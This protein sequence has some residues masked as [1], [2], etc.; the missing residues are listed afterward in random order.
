MD[1]QT[2]ISSVSTQV[3]VML[4]LIILGYI[5][6]KKYVLTEKGTSEL[7]NI[8]L[9][10][11]IPCVIMK[12]Y[13]MPFDK[14]KIQKLFF[15]YFLCFVIHI[16]YIVLANVFFTVTKDLKDR[17]INSISSVYSNCGFMAIPL[18]QACLGTQGVFYGSAYFGVFNI[19]VWVDAKRRLEENT[20]RKEKVNIL[21]PGVLGVLLGLVLYLTQIKLPVFIY[22]PISFIADLN[23][24]LAMLILG[25]LL[26]RSNIFHSF[27][28]PGVY[29]VSLFKL[30]FAP[31]L[32]AVVMRLLKTD[33]IVALSVIICAACPVATTI[34]IFAQKYNINYEYAANLTVVTTLFS[35]ITIPLICI[36]S[37]FIF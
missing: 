35:L 29:L 11:V 27:K 6:S 26:A 20:A 7:S 4:I 23:T 5:L 12:A 8:L 21:N 33:V 3:C 14:S 28:N 2:V 34:P 36:V 10:V 9:N 31:L 25:N 13:Y 30:F 32:L 22:N 37:S 17:K 16:L 24:P 15:A 1:F 18:L 19:L